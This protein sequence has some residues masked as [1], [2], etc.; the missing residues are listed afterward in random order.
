MDDGRFLAI[1]LHSLGDVILCQPAAAHLASRGGVTFVTAAGCL[2]VVE[3]FGHGVRPLGLR[4]SG[5]AWSLLGISGR[6]GSADI[7][8][9]QGNAT[10]FLGTGLRRV[11]RFRTDRRRRSAALKG[12]G[13][14]PSRHSEFSSL[15]GSESHPA[16]VLERRCPP[17]SEFTVGLVCGG[18]WRM[19]S[20]PEDL[21]A[22]LARLFADLE[23]A[24]VLLLGGAEDR[25]AM[26]SVRSLAR[27]DCVTRSD[28]GSGLDGLLGSIERCSLL[29]SPDSGPAHA[30][31]A[32]GVPTLVVFTSTSPVLGFFDLQGSIGPAAPCSPCHRHGADSCR[33]GDEACRRAL[34]PL[35]IH[36]AALA[37]LGGRP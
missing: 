9:F 37:L 7:F 32:L 8:D 26:E 23:G 29:V 24:S 2:P 17:P 36:R 19:K 13:A 31:R 34:L 33:M 20:L 6:F 5:A 21:L 27:R 22:E 35:E 18:R 16:P 25:A 1:R 12:K 4:G 10:T 11:H 28:P 30:G 15:A 14:M 3:R